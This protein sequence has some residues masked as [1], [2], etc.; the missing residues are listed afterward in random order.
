[1]ATLSGQQI[2]NRFS[3]LLKTSSDSTLTSS[4]TVVEDGAGNDSDLHIATGKVKVAT[5]LGIGVD[6]SVGKLH[7]NAGTSQAVTVDN[8]NASLIIGKGTQYSFCIGDCNPVSTVGG[9]TSS[10]AAQANENY[11]AS[12]TGAHSG[13]GQIM[14]MNG[15]SAGTGAI[16]IGQ[17]T[18]ANG[19]IHFGD[20]D[21]KFYFEGRNTTQAFDIY[22]NAETL[23]SVDGANKRIGIGENVTAPTSTLEV[24]ETGSATNEITIVS[25]TNKA[26]AASM[27]DTRAS[28]NWNQWYYDGS[29]P[30]VS[31]AGKINVG[32]ETNWTSTA[33]T[34]DSY[35]SFATVDGSTSVTPREHVRITSAGYVGIGTAAPTERLDVTGN[36]HISGT[37]TAGNVVNE[38]FNS[39]YELSDYFEQKPGINADI[40]N[41]DGAIR[42]IVSRNFEIQGDGGTSALCTFDTARS[43][44]LL[45]TDTSDDDEMVIL[46]HQDANQTAWS[47]ITWG[48]DNQ[49]QWEC[50]IT[51]HDTEAN[52][53]NNVRYVAGLGQNATLLAAAHNHSQYTDQVLFYYDSDNSASTDMLRYQEST[54]TWHCVYSNNGTDYVTNLGVTL[55]QGTTYKL[56]IVIDSNRKPAVYIND[57]QYGLTV[58]SGVGDTGVNV[59][60]AVSLSSG[61]S[62]VITVSGTSATAQ[63][64]VGDVITNSAGVPWGTVTAVTSTTSITI[65]AASTKSFPDAS[66]IYVYGRAASSTTSLGAVLKDTTDLVPQISVTTR[67]TAAKTLTVHYQKISRNLI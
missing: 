3:S 66:D 45:T 23:F 9:G 53:K 4:L 62:H 49:V 63:L 60:G 11:I 61:S 12:N 47:N 64:V 1:M 40:Q 41:V 14:I 28:I 25:L 24:S 33:S 19:F 16:G 58:I 6:P 55:T 48:T 32:T 59:N 37:L 56:K 13:A 26:N 57:V 38:T 42:M 21:K 30:A 20:A 54:T 5:T 67:T 34:R 51:P 22:A 43:G 27:I 18:I 8:G 39:R 36:V 17:D 52:A 10:T 7:I 65:T 15:A 44:I 29:S 2:A 46:P 31:K 35:M 50:A